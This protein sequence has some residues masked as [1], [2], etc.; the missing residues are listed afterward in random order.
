VGS[1]TSFQF[2]DTSNP[3]ASSKKKVARRTLAW[4]GDEAH[5]YESVPGARCRISFSVSEGRLMDFALEKSSGLDRLQASSR[6]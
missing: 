2:T 5:P 1:V 6:L 4:N 3:D